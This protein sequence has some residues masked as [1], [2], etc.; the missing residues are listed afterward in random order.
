MAA[1]WANNW[2]ADNLEQSRDPHDGWGVLPPMLPTEPRTAIAKQIQPQSQ[3]EKNLSLNSWVNSQAQELGSPDPRNIARARDMQFDGLVE[4]RGGRGARANRGNQSYQSG[5]GGWVQN[6]AWVGRNVRAQA[7]QSTSWS[8]TEQIPWNNTPQRYPVD[9]QP[10]IPTNKGALTSHGNATP[11]QTE[12][13]KPQET[14]SQQDGVKKEDKT[15]LKP[16]ETKFDSQRDDVNATKQDQAGAS[17]FSDQKNDWGSVSQKKQTPPKQKVPRSDTLN[18]GWN[19]VGDDK[20]PQSRDGNQSVRKDQQQ[21]RSSGQRN[22]GN[23]NRRKNDVEKKK[24]NRF[25]TTA[26]TRP[27]PEPD[28]FDNE[29]AQVASDHADNGFLDTKVLARADKTDEGEYSLQAWDGGW[30]PAPVDWED[31]PSNHDKNSRGRV[32]NWEA[33]AAAEHDIALHGERLGDVEGDICPRSWVPESIDDKLPDEWWKQNTESEEYSCD[34]FLYDCYIQ[35]FWRR[36]KGPATEALRKVEVPEPKVD[37]NDNDI[38]LLTQTVQSTIAD[39]L[40]KTHNRRD[41]SQKH[42]AMQ[43]ERAMLDMQMGNQNQ[44][45]PKLNCYLRPVEPSDMPQ[46]HSIWNHWIERSITTPELTALPVSDV[47]SRWADICEASLPFLVAV[48]RSA[49]SLKPRQ[50]RTSTNY[51]TGNNTNN[52]P[53]E[54]ILGFTFAD[55]FNDIRGMYRYTVELEVFIK[56][57][58]QRKGIGRCLVDKMLQIL[59]VGYDPRGGYD[60][61]NEDA[62]YRAGGSRTIGNIIV[63]VPYASDDHG[64]LKWKKAWLGQFKFEKVGELTDIGR[65]L[66]KK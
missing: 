13:L 19:A 44:H 37:R 31:R 16:Q 26:E 47:E 49:K 45:S 57:D 10:D 61:P 15:T 21:A 52:E 39:R 22:R 38:L 51:N 63:N 58:C 32:M 41:K 48:D 1:K 54:S 46:I 6:A 24:N 5:R 8:Q 34:P 64:P 25:A 11:H 7:Q 65:K 12:V 14:D 35:P 17:K 18:N 20:T 29:D 50:R 9:T 36:F 4:R 28:V 40:Q 66:N 55:D 43:R 30:A 59:D 53:I 3:R 23:T 27:D 42:V 33:H 56:N 2:A 60:F 62:K